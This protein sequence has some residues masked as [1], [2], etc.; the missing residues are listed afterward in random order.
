MNNTQHLMWFYFKP[1]TKS[2]M[3]NTQHLMWFYFEPYTKIR[4]LTEHTLQSFY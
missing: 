4:N 3:N 1:Y 2:E